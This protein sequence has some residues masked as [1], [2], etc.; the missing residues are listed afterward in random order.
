MYALYGKC[1]G[2]DVR[3]VPMYRPP[4]SSC[5]RIAILE[6]AEYRLLRIRMSSCARQF[7]EQLCSDGSFTAQLSTLVPGYCG[8]D[9][10]READTTV[11]SSMVTGREA[12]LANSSNVTWAGQA[13]MTQPAWMPTLFSPFPHGL[14]TG[15][16]FPNSAE[17]RH[18]SDSAD[19]HCRTAFSA[20]ES[21]T[22]SRCR[23]RSVGLMA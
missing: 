17:P 13:D 15:G 8:T 20:R 14:F 9:K 12:D 18:S 16:I 7:M 23:S 22:A 3:W 4:D 2:E 6:N 19:S 21:C 10:E 1:A 5:M 11:S